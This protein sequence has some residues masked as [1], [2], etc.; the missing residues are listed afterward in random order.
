MIVFL[1]MIMF[2]IFALTLQITGLILLYKQGD[3][4]IYG[5]Q[6]YLITTLSIIDITFLTLSA[7]LQ[8]ISQLTDMP[9]EIGAF[10]I[11]YK[12]M[13]LVNM[14]YFTMFG[15]IIDR[16][17]QIRLNIRYELY[18]NKDMSKKLLLGYC[19]ML[20][21][22]YF[23]YL[24]IALSY[25]Q[26]SLNMKALETFQ[27][28]LKP[29]YSVTFVTAASSVFFYIFRKICF[30]RKKH[31]RT[32]KNVTSRHQI[33]HQRSSLVIYLLPFGIIIAFILFQILPD[34]ILTF[35]FFYQ[36]PHLEIF[37]TLIIVLYNCG[38]I[39]DPLIY[40]FNL[41]VVRSKLK[42]MKGN[43]LSCFSY[44]H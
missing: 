3:R 17:L 5:T 35:C 25:Q 37:Q 21:V 30:N 12:L 15:I 31:E 36:I 23:T 10:I 32:K 39:A 27:K 2:C 11:S 7:T 42:I 4:N 33:S 44:R 24:T 6:K 40:M 34:A 41:Q 8:Y 9:Y 26:Y 38:F 18:W 28:Y 13:V 19:V 1:V 14:F 16:F 22:L 20:N 29:V 43:I